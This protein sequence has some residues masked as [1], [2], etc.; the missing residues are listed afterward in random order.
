MKKIL[1]LVIL[2]FLSACNG[3]MTIMPRGSGQITKGTVFANGFG[4][5]TMT[6]DVNG[7]IY[8]GSFV[9]TSSSDSF[10]FFQQ[11][12]K[13]Q[14]STGTIQ[15]FGSHNFGKAILSSSDN[16]GLRCE[17]EGD[18]LGHGSAICLDDEGKIYD[19]IVQF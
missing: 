5:G 7:R 6:M 11:Y 19:A 15:T 16:H 3:T 2:T 12:G 8:T 14:V 18:G 4:S 1:T 17:I 10:G 13:G 9:K